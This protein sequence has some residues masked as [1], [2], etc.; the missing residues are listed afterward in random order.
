MRSVI[1]KIFL[2]LIFF[3]TV[4]ACISWWLGAPENSDYRE[5]KNQAEAGIIR[6]MVKFDL[7]KFPN[8]YIPTD[9]VCENIEG[10]ETASYSLF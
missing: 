9:L 2:Y 7:T 5:D 10:V 3:S 6:L 4:G 1:K 8:R